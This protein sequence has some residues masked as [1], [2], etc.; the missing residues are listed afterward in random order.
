LSRPKISVSGGR[1]F[2]LLTATEDYTSE[3]YA[4]THC[5]VTDPEYSPGVHAKHKASTAS[6]VA[7]LRPRLK[8]ARLP[9]IGP[10]ASV[11]VETR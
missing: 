9:G 3:R 11:E 1:Y 6:H 4:G 10:D 8:L 2:L 5:L 7:R